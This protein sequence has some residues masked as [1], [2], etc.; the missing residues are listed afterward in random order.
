MILHSGVGEQTGLGKVLRKRL[1]IGL[2]WSS[3]A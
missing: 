2:Y 3:R 1:I